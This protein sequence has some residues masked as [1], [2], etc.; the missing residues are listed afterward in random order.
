MISNICSVTLPILV[1]LVIPRRDISPMLFR[2]KFH[3]QI[4]EKMREE[5]KEEE[6][7]M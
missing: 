1:G 6:G 7:K 5:E 2:R 3:Y 4:K